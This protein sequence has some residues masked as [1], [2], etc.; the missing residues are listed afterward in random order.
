MAELRI[1]KLKPIARVDDPNWDRAPDRGEI[2]V[3]ARSPADARVV[4]AAAENDL[5]DSDAKPS[6]GVSTEFASAF[7]DEKLYTVTEDTSGR[8]PSEGER[9]IVDGQLGQ[10]TNAALQR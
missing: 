4:A 3:R 5:L 8:F 7:R 10:E 2:T 1:F 9:G 6:H